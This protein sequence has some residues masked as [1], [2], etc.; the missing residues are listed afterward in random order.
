[1]KFSEDYPRQREALN[2]LEQTI[3]KSFRDHT[4][5][6]EAIEQRIQMLNLS[7]HEETR[8]I[9]QQQQILEKLPIAP[10]A[11]FSSY[12]RTRRP[13]C[14]TDTRVEILAKIKEWADDDHQETL[15]W[16][17]GFAGIGKSTIAQ[18]VACSYS[19]QGRLGANFFFSQ[20]LGGDVRRSRK[21]FTSI[22][23]QLAQFSKEIKS[24]IS[25]AIAENEGIITQGLAK[26][27]QKLILGPLSRIKVDVMDDPI[28]I[29][30]DALDECDD[31]EDIEL[32]T[33][34]LPELGQLKN[35][36]FKIFI[37]SRPESFV[38]DA[39]GKI[40]ENDF[41]I[42]ILH[43]VPRVQVD[44]DIS[45]LFRNEFAAIRE[46]QNLPKDWP[47]SRDLE[48]VVQ[49]AGGLFV[50]ADT[51]CRF[52]RN[53]GIFTLKRFKKLLENDLFT[54][55]PEKGLDNLYLTVL[56]D[57]IST[58]YV[59]YE[60]DEIEEF[61]RILNLI[62]KILVISFSSLSIS[63][64]NEIS[65]VGEYEISEMLSNF[66]AILDIH[67]EYD[68][69]IQLHHPSF[70][71]FLLNEKRCKDDRFLVN[72]QE[73]HSFM[74]IACIRVMSSGL[75][76]DICGLRSPGVLA[77]DVC[78]EDIEEHLPD[79]LHYA[80]QYWAYHVHRSSSRIEST[81]NVHVFLQQ[82]LTHWLEAL[83][84]LGKLSESVTAISL[85]STLVEEVCSRHSSF[86]IVARA[87]CA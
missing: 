39:F 45:L 49:R 1:M 64:L 35:M 84:L 20:D 18:T 69:P 8:S 10:E 33:R 46:K 60:D 51:A 78:V 26:Q 40:S 54:T 77:V 13:T 86:F 2:S 67:E 66:H 14:L 11:E 50:W 9:L 70:R 3:L 23:W 42:L 75:K 48:V 16:L 25:E 15:F 65:G 43:S 29:L 85:L 22:A 73:A 32:I 27:W 30:I 72:E 58:K 19:E 38:R 81:S 59:K 31:S 7:S 6:V 44:E 21:L 12:E 79:I 47:G 56:E 24:Q 55:A 62:F 74:A 80:C 41:Q 52:V 53:G 36:K 34:L 82:H 61:C 37:T 83:S 87:Y 17:R 5:V 28:L 76:K 71:D 57:S 68:Y 63:S 4:G